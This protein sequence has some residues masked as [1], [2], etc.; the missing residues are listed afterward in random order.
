[1]TSNRIQPDFHR[2]KSYRNEHKIEGEKAP[3][4]Q[5]QFEMLISHLF[6]SSP[7]S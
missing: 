7:P 1:M 5:A 3:I 2:Y 6:D 4:I